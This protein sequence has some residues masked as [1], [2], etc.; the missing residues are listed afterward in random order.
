V[1]IWRPT[2][3]LGAEEKN[4]FRSVWRGPFAWRSWGRH[5][6]GLLDP[7]L[8]DL[9]PRVPLHKGIDE[10]NDG[11]I[12][13]ALAAQSQLT[14]VKTDVSP[15]QLIDMKAVGLERSGIRNN[16]HSASAIY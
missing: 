5:R 11:C 10:P 13:P 9:A 15:A 3:P 7:A 16:D 12:R 4:D 6:V 1:G 8:A 14:P 2:I